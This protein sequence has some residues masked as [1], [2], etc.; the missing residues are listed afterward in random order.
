VPF[1]AVEPLPIDGTSFLVQSGKYR[2]CVEVADTSDGSTALVLNTCDGNPRQMFTYNPD[3]QQIQSVSTGS[4][5]DDNGTYEDDE[6]IH[7]KDLVPKDCDPSSNGQ[8]WSYDLIQ[9]VVK[10]S[11]QNELCLDD[12]NAWGPGQGIQVYPCEFA[13]TRQVFTI[14]LVGE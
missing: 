2:L 1:V 12:K 4:C 7:I 10:D 3:T 9:R 8:K 13:N 14:S 6:G 5:W 11:G